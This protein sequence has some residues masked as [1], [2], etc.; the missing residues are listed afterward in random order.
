MVMPGVVERA[1]RAERIFFWRLPRLAPRAIKAVVA[2][3]W[4]ISSSGKS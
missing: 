2:V 4:R 1:S 3:G